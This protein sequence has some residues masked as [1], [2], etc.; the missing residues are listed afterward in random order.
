VDILDTEDSNYDIACGE[1]T[2][3]RGGGRGGGQRKRTCQNNLN[4]TKT[5]LIS[6]KLVPLV[7]YVQTYI[8]STRV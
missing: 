5:K 4:D 3:D 2:V 8:S 1:S 6:A 7:E